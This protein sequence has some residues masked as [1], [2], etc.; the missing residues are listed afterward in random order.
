MPNAL[1][2]NLKQVLRRLGPL[3]VACIFAGAVWLLYREISKYSVADIRM[4]LSRISLPH[5]LLSVF[6]TVINYIILIGYDWLALKG[7]HKSLPLTKVSLVSFVGQAVS[8]NFGALLGGST[9]RY[10]FYSAWGFS[11]ID[12]V[13]LVLMLAI[14]FWVGALGLVG[15]IFMIAPPAI[16]PEL[17]LHL[18]VNDIRPLGAVLFLAAMSYLV[19]CKFVHKPIH[20]FGK[21]FAFPPFRIAVAQA[22]VAGADLVA[23][24]ACLYVLLPPDSGLSFIEFLPTYL[25]AMVAVVLTH[26]PGGAGV[27]EVIILHLTSADP[28][29]IFAALICFRAI[30]YLLPLLMAAI[31]FAI[32]EIRQQTA[33]ATGAIHDA[34]RWMRA[35]SPTVMAFAVFGM[36]ALLCFSVT[37]PISPER[38]ER[39][40]AWIPLQIMESASVVAGLVGCALLFLAPGLQHRQHHAWR[41]IMGL[42]CIGLVASLASSLNWIVA[43]LLVAGIFSVYSIRRRCCRPSSLWKL[44]VSPR[45]LIGSVAIPACA[46]GIGIVLHHADPFPPEFWSL[47]G[48][49][50]EA[51]RLARIM[52]A[53]VLLFLALTLGYARTA[54]LRRRDAKKKAN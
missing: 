7:I 48:Y 19:V 49:T 1:W 20:I 23:A 27:L 13:R 6:L 12:I 25:L 18:P 11:P 40:V 21:E 44:R 15:A 50:A 24:G 41:L 47:S 3:L 46:A 17:G 43:L 5:I 39:T 2:S 42:L 38:L 33:Q 26:V 9:V 14:T 51:P 54:P 32:Y 30:Y 28:Q 35:F 45:W 16:P 10:R 31:V 8:Y 36:G 53:Q 52:T 29:D 4:S 37:L 22:L 34:S